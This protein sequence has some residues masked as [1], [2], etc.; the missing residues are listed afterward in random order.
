MREIKTKQIG[1]FNYR[2]KQ[3]PDP[4]GTRL[5]MRLIR[6]L[7]PSL[8][9]GLKGLPEG[10]EGISVA[11]L[12]TK[13]L[14]DAIIALGDSLSEDDFLFICDTLSTDAEFSDGNTWF[15][16]TSDKSH[17]SGRYLQKFQWLVFAL[18]VNYADF[19]GGTE[20]LARVV[21]M[22]QNAQKSKSQATST[23]EPNES[24]PV[25]TTP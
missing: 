7:T 18:E 6:V 4:M 5:L 1:S 8:G 11:E 23:G 14:G 2:V 9:A 15:P 3:L 25:N 13:A 12:T 21:A 24:S 10:G 20:S 17:W 22:V 19:L 16:M